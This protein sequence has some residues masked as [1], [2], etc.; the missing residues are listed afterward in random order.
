MNKTSVD[1]AY[2]SLHKFEEELC[3][4]RV[5]IVH[6][7]DSTILILA[8]GMGSGVKA[9]ILSTLTSKILGT[10]LE[11]GATLDECVETLVSTLPVCQERHVAYAT[12]SILQIFQDGQAYLVEFDNPSCIFIRQNQCVDLQFNHRIIAGK[13]IHEA[14]FEVKMDDYFILMSDGAIYAGTGEVLNLDW[15]RESI[16]EYAL[17]LSEEKPSASRLANDISDTCKAL[18]MDMPG[19]DTTIAVMKISPYR[20]V[21]IFTGPPLHMEDDEKLVKDFMQGDATKIVSGGTSSHI[22]AR[23]LKE[24]LETDYASMNDDVPPIAYMPGVDLVTEGIVTLSKTLNLLKKYTASHTDD[25]FKILDQHNGASMLA[26]ILIEECHECVFFIGQA[27]NEAHQNL[28]LP[29]DLS[30]RMNVVEQ[31]KQVLESM[32]KKVKMLYY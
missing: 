27:M 7:I 5:E 24:E 9:N 17:G 25:F 29:F 21:H 2:K 1:V 8:D 30:M 16:A 19:D 22:I 32:G 31:L 26:K 3:G 10:M 11:K 13:E 18:Y 6:T 12:F 14:H 23:I 15:T 20:K 4:D 28:N